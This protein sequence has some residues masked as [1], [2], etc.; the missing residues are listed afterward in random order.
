[1]GKSTAGNFFLNSESFPTAEGF[2][3]CT[4][5]CSVSTSIICGKKIKII[6]TPGFFD[7]FSSAE[8]NFKEL[9]KT[10]TLAI[11]GIHAV[12]FVMRYGRFTKACK[13][14]IQHL[15]LLT[16]VLPF[17]FILLTHTKRNG[18]TT[19]ETAEYI[20]QC[21]TSNR[22]PTGLRDLMEVVESRVIM[23]EAVE[24]IAEDYHQQ[25]CNELLMMVEKIHKRNGNK[26]Y[27][28][29]ALQHA[30]EV[31]ECVKQQQRKEAQAITQSL[32]SNSQKIEQLKQ[33]INDT[34]YDKAA[35]DKIG[36]EITVLQKEN[37]GLV[38]R[39]EEINNEQYLVQL[40]NE[41]LENEIPKDSFKG[42]LLDYFST[43]AFSTVGSVVGGAFGMMGGSKYTTTMGFAAGAAAGG[44]LG[45]TIRDR[46]CN[47]Q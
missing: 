23:L 47:Q 4:E 12:A 42:S 16:G 38:K 11:D 24:Y 7:E 17:V 37:E 25:K 39:L 6:D 5:H 9:N 20:E 28:N 40:T 45:K 26:V 46:N 22:C 15:Q 44:A 29:I 34:A 21:L 3:G 18:V 1:M 33:Q 19:T 31:H 43:V 35:A 32:E 13:E 36:K 8:S 14:A 41:I 2:I 27:T 30:A 10:L